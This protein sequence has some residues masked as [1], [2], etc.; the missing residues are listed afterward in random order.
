LELSE[1]ADPR[2]RPIGGFNA[3]AAWAGVT[4]FIFMVFGAL[5]VQISVV[6]QFP[7]TD[8]QQSSWITITWLTAAVVTVP[9]SLYFRQPLAIGWTIPGIVYMGS[10]ANSFT[11]AEFAGAN[12]AAGVLIVLLGLAGFGSKVI[13]LVPMPILMG[14][15]GASGRRRTFTCHRR[16]L[17][18]R[19][20]GSIS[21]RKPCSP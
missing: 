5:T 6:E 3:A 14:M 9:L 19:L 13:Q 20:R 11:L 15:F 18:S 7:I 4:A 8:V 21:A 12:L 17:P 1:T 16:C 2:Q 10:L